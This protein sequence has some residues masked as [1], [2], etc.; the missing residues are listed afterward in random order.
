M[1]TFAVE[2]LLSAVS[3]WC[4]QYTLTKLQFI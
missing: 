1:H 3:A 2:V 4:L